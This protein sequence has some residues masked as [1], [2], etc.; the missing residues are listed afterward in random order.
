MQTLHR[1]GLAGTRLARA[2]CGTIRDKVL[3][4]GAQVLVSVRR[5]C[6]SFDATWPCAALLRAALANSA[7]MPLRC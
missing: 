7:A 6:L 5:V 3:K 2:Q 4:A 1:V